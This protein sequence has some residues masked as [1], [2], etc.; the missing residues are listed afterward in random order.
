MVHHIEQLQCDDNGTYNYHYPCAFPSTVEQD[1][2]HY[3]KMLMAPDRSQ[4]AEAMQKEI[5]G[6]HH[7][8]EVIPRDDVPPTHKPLPAVWAFKRKRR[9]D[10]S[11]LKWKARINVH[12]GHQK[13]GVNYWE[14]YAPV[15]NWSTVRLTFI[16][17][18]LQGF[19]TKQVD[20][21]QAFTQAP[22]D[23]PIYMEVPAGFDVIDGVL[24]FVGESVKRTDRK[25]V[26][27]LR[28][29]MYGLKQAGHNWY[30]HLTDDLLQHGFCQSQVN[31]CLFI[32]HDCIILIYVD[33]CLIFSPSQ[34]T[35]QEITSH[36]EKVFKITS[37]DDVAAYL[38]IDISRNEKGHLVLRQ[39]G[40]ID[41]VINICGL[42]M[43]SNAHRTPAD[44]ILHP[45][46]PDDPPRQL[47]WSYCQVIGILNYMAATSWPDISYAVH[48][49]ARFSTAPR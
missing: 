36:L 13:H 1:T 3:G 2:L 21:V 28:K 4:F 27:R 8:L 29:N 43:E 30:K 47:H 40:L 15:V 48:Q 11:I 5:D 44:Q 10:Y 35:L 17:S 46:M 41:K 24:T 14:T 38:G 18:L 16:L 7:I 37:D 20:F 42:E 9:P 22:L 23:C 6:I 26:L 19:H 33:D 32:R 45:P 25:H 34:T 12:G 31:K 39:P 49:C